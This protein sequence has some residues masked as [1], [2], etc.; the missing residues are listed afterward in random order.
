VLAL[1]WRLVYVD[2][3]PTPYHPMLQYQSAIVARKTWLRIRA[4]TVT[5]EQQEWLQSSHVR[6]TAPPLLPVLTA[7]TYLVVGAELP[8][9]SLIYNTLFWLLGSW[10][11][12]Q[13]VKHI[14]DSS[15]A[16]TVSVGYYLLAPLGITVSRSFQPESL[17][18][19]GF[20][21]ALW[22]LVRTN[23]IQTWAQ[24]VSSG[25]ICASVLL[26]KPGILF[27]PLLAGYLAIAVKAHGW[28]QV[29][30]SPQLYVFTGLM[31]IPSAVYSLVVLRDSFSARFVPQLLAE[32]YFYRNW[33]A[34]AGGSTGWVPLLVAILGS[35]W[36]VRRRG[37]YLGV[38]LLLSFLVYSLVFTWHSM[39]HD[40]Y[41]VPLLTIIAIS[42]GPAACSLEEN[43][44]WRRLPAWTRGLVGVSLLVW[45][46]IPTLAI[47]LARQSQWAAQTATVQEI[48]S[49][50]STVPYGTHVLC[51]NPVDY[52]YPLE[53]H[54][55]L[56]TFYWPSEF[57]LLA[58]RIRTGTVIPVATRFEQILCEE[59]PAFFVI[60][61][62]PELKRQPEVAKLMDTRYSVCH[63]SRGVVIYDLR[64]PRQR[65]E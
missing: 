5:P 41:H 22:H 14:C 44:S 24:T 57:D 18:T 52:G 7:A 33:W 17:M 30:F 36:L 20:L 23:G 3:W 35:L 64:R 12:F 15:F 28:R 59:H 55:W 56:A 43:E 13:L 16:A 53:Y 1:E 8:W 4:A 21:V 54:G 42:L 40:Y 2:E 58:E 65:E 63:R 26:I 50:R 27:F 60:T 47:L 32:A 6:F 49:F 61:E 34:L 46:S 10:F 39:T 9:V 25:L 51:L 62:P 48:E 38:G 29:L 19:C 45:I 11:L 31:L 37:H